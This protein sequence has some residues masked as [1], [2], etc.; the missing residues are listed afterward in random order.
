MR[1]MEIFCILIVVV[2][3]K[4]YI[5]VETHVIALYCAH[6]PQKGDSNDVSEL[7]KKE[8]LNRL[9]ILFSMGT[10]GEK[11]ST[12]TYLCYVF[13]GYIFALFALGYPVKL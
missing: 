9:I 12:D 5:I 4:V 2:V 7:N 6:T 13:V 11:G 10:G 8:H 3:L 1:V